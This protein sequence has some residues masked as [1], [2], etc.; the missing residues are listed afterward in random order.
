MFYNERVYH[1]VYHIFTI[2]KKMCWKNSK[3]FEFQM[4]VSEKE[5]NT[6]LSLIALCAYVLNT[7]VKFS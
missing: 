6:I 3:A 4:K 5:N 2:N 1:V 7:A